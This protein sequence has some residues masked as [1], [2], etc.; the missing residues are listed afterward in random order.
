MIYATIERNGVR[1][2]Q[3]LIHLNNNKFNSHL[4][5]YKNKIFF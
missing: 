1:V 5:R 2:K 3:A 4:K